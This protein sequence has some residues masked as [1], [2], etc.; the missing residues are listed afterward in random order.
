MR[1]IGREVAEFNQCYKM[2]SPLTIAELA[3]LYLSIM[4][5]LA[6]EHFATLE[7][8]IAEGK[9][10]PA[11]PRRTVPGKKLGRAFMDEAH[12]EVTSA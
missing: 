7:Q 2:S 3:E 4:K 10:S 1:D 6:A 11:K 9:A 8:K 12:H 5:E